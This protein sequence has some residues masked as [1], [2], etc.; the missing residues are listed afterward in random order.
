M[1]GIPAIA[2]TIGAR[3]PAGVERIWR[4]L[5]R[6]LTILTLVAVA[7]LGVAAPASAATPTF[8]YMDPA[9]A[10]LIISAIIGG[11]AAFGMIIKKFWYRITGVF[12]GGKSEPAPATDG[13]NPTPQTGESSIPSE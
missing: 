1:C 4:Y 12:T 6:R 2:D 11:F 9:S 3:S 13:A 8:A 7:T 10:T 5:L